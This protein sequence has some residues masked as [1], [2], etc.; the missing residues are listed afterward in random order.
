MAYKAEEIAK[1]I[2][3]K[4]NEEGSPIN[5]MQ[6]QNILYCLQREYLKMRKT[7]LFNDDFEAWKFGVVVPSVYYKYCGHGAMAIYM[8]YDTAIEPQEKEIIDRM[9]R[10]KRALPIWDLTQ[11]TQGERKAWHMIYDNGSGDHRVIPKE[12]I[13]NRG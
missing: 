4:C 12:L 13:R 5:N 6:L 8:R 1:Y 10:K 3:T 9:V 11:D 7:P 2:I